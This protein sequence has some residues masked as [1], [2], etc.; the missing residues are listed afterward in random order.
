[1]AP[2][3]R[4]ARGATPTISRGL[5][6]D[7]VTP[8]DL[9]PYVPEDFDE[10][11]ETAREEAD[12][13][14][15]DY[16]RSRH[17]VFDLPGFVVETIDFRSI[18]GSSL[19]GWVAIPE[20][21]NRMAPS[22]LWLP[23]YGKESHLPNEYSTREDMVSM[24]FNF[25]GNDAFHQEDYSPLRGY[26]AEGVEDPETW[27]FREMLQNALIAVRVLRA[28][29]E[30]DASRLSVAGMSQGGGMAIWTGATSSAVKAVVADMPFLA[31]MR[32]TLHQPIHRYPLKELADFAHR[33]PLGIERV[34]YTVSYYDT[35]N[36]AT[37][38]H[39]PALVSYG[40]RDP[41]SRPE[42]VRAVYDAIPGSKKLLEYPGGHD[43]DTGMIEANRKF[44]LEA[45]T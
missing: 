11:W 20:R 2:H 31:G 26:F 39:K 44:M 42:H 1:M 36:H 40:A 21:L 19:H 30:A 6:F 8:E 37:R 32:R 13:S 34:L 29:V 27:V 43:W 25:H 3:H 28:Q 41:A 22:F 9:Q 23:A 10:F 18:G 24:S 15:L 14:P 17:N 7:P 45:T 33:I 38:L 35:V 16:H 12:K 5:I 4:I